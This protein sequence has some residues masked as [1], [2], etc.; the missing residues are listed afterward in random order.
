MQSVLE[1]S[2]NEAELAKYEIPIIARGKIITDYTQVYGGRHGQATFITPDVNKYLDKILLK[3]PSQLKDL[4]N[5][6]I[7]EIL[8]FMDDLGKRL[9]IEENEYLQECYELACEASG[10]TPSVLHTTYKALPL[11]LSKETLHDMLE[12]RIGIKFLEG[13]VPTTLS[14]GRTVSVRAFGA[15]TAHIIAGN[16]PLVA[17]GTI[18]RSACTR[19][20]TI[21]K[22]PSNDPL[23]ATALA[24]TMI[25]MDPNHPITKS[26]T[27]IYF[28]G[29]DEAF[30]T[31]FYRPE[32]IEKIIAWGGFASIKHITKYMQPGIDLITLDPKLSMSIIGAQAF[33]N[34]NTLRTAAQRAAI[35]IGSFNQ[36]ACVNSR[37][38]YVQSGTDEQGITNLNQ[39]GAY[40][41][42]SLTSLPPHVSTPSKDFDLSLKAN[43]DGLRMDE[44]FYKVYGGEG[45]E[46][47]VIVS[48]FD[49]PVDFSDQLCGR[50]VNLVPIDD[51]QTAVQS[52]NAYTQT[53][54]IYPETLKASIRDDLILNGVQ[55]IVSL[56]YAPSGSFATPQDAIEPLRRMCKWV[57]D[58]SSVPI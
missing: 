35:D 29:G 22:L 21:I 40:L 1:K 33:L 38:I 32:H 47:A 13:W 2:K 20:D 49:E 44:S 58:E 28:K 45:N 55:R 15:R 31:Q 9:V 37:V 11:F 23:T 25:D 43:I 39:L 6:S 4:Y 42:Y 19:C 26:V 57:M 27:V 56:G 48:Q 50:V 46:G 41:Y 10:L 54:G 17:A 30:E 12:K 51:I 36:E 7:E 24:R 52:V 14:D 3:N 34:E 5:L 18:A 53:V 16:V 8:E